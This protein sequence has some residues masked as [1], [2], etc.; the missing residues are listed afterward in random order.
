MR[1]FFGRL[2]G[3]FTLSVGAGLTIIVLTFVVIGWALDR[4]L[5]SIDHLLEQVIQ[6]EE[7][8]SAAANELEIYLLGTGL[9][10][11][12]YPAT[13]AAEHRECVSKD[14]SDFQRFR[15]E[16]ERLASTAVEKDLGERLD[17]LYEP[18]VRLSGVLMDTR[19]G[20]VARLD[21]ATEAF[22]TIDRILDDSIQPGIVAT[23][24]EGVAKLLTSTTIEADVAEIGAWLGSYLADPTADH[25]QRILESV[26]EVRGALAA[27]LDLELTLEERAGADRID[28]MLDPTVAIIEQAVDLHESLRQ[29]EAAFIVL[30]NQLDDL[31]DEGIQVLARQDL[32]AAQPQVESAIHRLYVGSLIVLVVGAVVCIGAAG[33]LA[34]RSVR[35][36]AANQELRREFERRRQSEDA[37]TRLLH[38]FVSVQE[39]ERGRL[40]RDLHDQM[41]QD[42]SALMLGLKRL[43][44][45]AARPEFLQ[46]QELTGRLL[47][48]VHT[49]AW[50]L[51]PVALDDLGVHGALSH[52]LEEWSDRSGL[53][54]DFESNLED[55][56][57]PDPVGIAL[58]R[59]AQEALTNVVKHARAR[60]VSLTLQRRSHE[61]V[62][63]VEDDG[64]GFVPEDVFPSS[65]AK[66]RLGVLGMK[67]RAAMA[68]RHAPGRIRSWPRHDAGGTNPPG[69]IHRLAR[70]VKKLRIVLADDHEM[71]RQGIKSLIEL[72][73]DLEVVGEDANGNAALDRV[74][75]LEPDRS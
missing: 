14:R 74:L 9:A 63:A 70:P 33:L 41:G 53:K 36:H 21:E 61:A 5:Q 11:W 39:K 62:M 71:F 35:L 26:E 54:V 38:E 69:V 18:Y 4:N 24:P 57:L 27:F 46:L 2:G 32:G 31:L 59:V 65:A 43:S 58:Y 42:L 13:G 66:G 55:Q 51:R 64:A 30:R 28:R 3:G 68:G 8:T 22:D 10:V 48:R 29:D 72:E 50:E 37:R 19:D 34:N 73:P 75:D 23:A 1:R 47:Q 20:F 44:R 60:T 12:K 17:A 52:H 45:P 25:R 49:I 67:E 15:A 56:R 6:V 40:A 16:Y 7:P